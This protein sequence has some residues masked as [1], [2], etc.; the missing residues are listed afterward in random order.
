MSSSASRSRRAPLDRPRISGPAVGEG[1]LRDRLTEVFA[2]FAAMAA[3]AEPLRAIGGR[4]T[5]R[6]S[7][8]VARSSHDGLSALCL[9]QVCSADWLC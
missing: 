4:L 1:R 6:L 8:A 2:L 3:L 5:T 9:R 7:S